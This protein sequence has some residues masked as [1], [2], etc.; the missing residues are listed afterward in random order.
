MNTQSPEDKLK[1][2]KEHLESE[3]DSFGSLDIP[4]AFSFFGMLDKGNIYLLDDRH[5]NILHTHDLVELGRV[6]KLVNE[7]EYKEGSC[8][9]LVETEKR[10]FIICF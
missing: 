8:M 6:K 9:R 5:Q 4:S 10:H 1:L 7:G 2:V 3:T